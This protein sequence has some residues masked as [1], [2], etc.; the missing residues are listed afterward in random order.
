MWLV[1]RPIMYCNLEKRK[2]ISACDQTEDKKC[3]RLSEVSKT[4]SIFNH[5]KVKI[6]P[7]K[8]QKE[9]TLRYFNMKLSFEIYL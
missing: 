3:L 4:S 7:N 8:F 9:N 5:L 1:L 2:K 6:I